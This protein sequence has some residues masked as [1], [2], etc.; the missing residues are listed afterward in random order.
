MSHEGP[1]KIME[2]VKQIALDYQ[3]RLS[4]AMDQLE[5]HDAR[6][7]QSPLVE[8]GPYLDFRTGSPVMK[9]PLV[10]FINPSSQIVELKRGIDIPVEFVLWDPEN[11]DFLNP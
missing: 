7:R 3:N 8:R 6:L 10:E 9:I 4:H 1:P 11:L 2:E 5:I